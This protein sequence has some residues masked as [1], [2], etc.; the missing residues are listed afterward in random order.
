MKYGFKYNSNTSFKIVPSND[1]A[2]YNIH[3]LKDIYETHLKIEL[4]QVKQMSDDEFIK[5][6][7]IK[8]NE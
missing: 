1:S 3:E 6:F 2:G 5:Y 8:E 4:D 7:G